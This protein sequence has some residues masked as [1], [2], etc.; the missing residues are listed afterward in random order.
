[1]ARARV[2]LAE[3]HAEVA[4][5]LQHILEAEFEV[6]AM[7]GDG[8][9]LVVIPAVRAALRGELYTSPRSM[10]VACGGRATR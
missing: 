1:M 3:D 4:E 7:G 2:V 9:A 6:V 5:L 8:H 10:N